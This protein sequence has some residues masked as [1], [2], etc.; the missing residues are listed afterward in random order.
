MKF[1]WGTGIAIFLILFVLSLV[2]VLIKSFQYD[3]S[4]VIDDYYK[5]DLAYQQ[6]YEKMANEQLSPLSV[7]I[8]RNAHQVTIDFPEKDTNI[9][10]TL[11]FYK[12]DNKALD[13]TLPVKIDGQNRMTVSTQELL[14]GLWRIKVDYSANN[15]AFY[16]EQKIVL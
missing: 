5:E 2:G 3:N 7:A 10:G 11:Q 15:E 12:P 9:I 14:R 16:Y 1:H 13:F 4:L 8:D 6:H